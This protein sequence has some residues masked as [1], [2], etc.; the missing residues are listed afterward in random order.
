MSRCFR[1]HNKRASKTYGW[2]NIGPI[3]QACLVL[4]TVMASTLPFPSFWPE[5][6]GER[7]KEKATLAS[8]CVTFH[9]Q[10]RR[11]RSLRR[12]ERS[13]TTNVQKIF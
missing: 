1:V 10:V 6:V 5:L 11:L 7:G 8:S 2:K 3:G 4:V 13:V 9:D 12:E